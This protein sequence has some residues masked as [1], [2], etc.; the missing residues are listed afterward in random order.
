MRGKRVG[1][2]RRVGERCAKRRRREL[3]GS[4]VWVGSF[5]KRGRE[6]MEWSFH[7]VSN[8]MIIRRGQRSIC[9][10]GVIGRPTN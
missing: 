1:I 2:T 6:G 7:V 5:W 8:T 9:F 3:K 10:R 4:N